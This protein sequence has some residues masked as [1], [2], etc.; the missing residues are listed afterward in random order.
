M[1]NEN[2]KPVPPAAGKTAKTLGKAGGYIVYN[3]FL[4]AWRCID[5]SGKQVLSTNSKKAAL[6][7][8]PNFIVK[9]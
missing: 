7:A 2:V 8:H 9:E 3:K 6:A 4:D 1:A 5:A